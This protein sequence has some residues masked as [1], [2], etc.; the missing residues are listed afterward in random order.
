MAFPSR[1]RRASSSTTRRS[2]PAVEALRDYGAKSLHA[3]PADP[4]GGA[5]A[6]VA[7]QGGFRVPPG[8]DRHQHAA[9]RGLRRQGR[10][11]PGFRPCRDRRAARPW[12][13]RALRLGLHP[14]GPLQGGDRAARRRREP[15]LGRGVVRRGGRLG[16]AR[17]DQRPG[18]QGRPCR[19]RLGPRLLRREPAAR[20]DPGRRL[21]LLRRGCDAGA[22]GL[23]IGP[24]ASR[25]ASWLAARHSV[26]L[27]CSSIQRCALEWRAPSQDY[28]AGPGGPRSDYPSKKSFVHFV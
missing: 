19:R 18:G 9:R 15:R 13:R 10:R 22:D 14:H 26:A 17:P 12:P 23:L 8:R 27:M 4:C 2:C 11:L 24:R 20:R 6:H 5:R 28:E 16:A 3:G 1:S 21:A 7:H 25:P